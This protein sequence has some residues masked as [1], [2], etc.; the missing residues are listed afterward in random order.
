L[1][2]TYEATLSGL[3][4]RAGRQFNVRVETTAS[5]FGKASAACFA[6][7]PPDDVRLVY[8][9]RGGAS[10]YRKF[11]EAAGRAQ[12]F[13]WV[14]RDLAAR[15]PELVHAPDCSTR[16]GFAFLLGDLLMDAAWLASHRNVR[17]SEANEIARSCAL[18]ELHQTRRAC[19][20]LRQQRVAEG[21]PDVRSEHLAETYATA[22][23]EAT[24]FRAHPS[25]FLP[26]LVPD[27]PHDRRAGSADLPP[28][29]YLRARLFAAVLGEYF[30]TRH[31][32]RWWA[33]SKAADE[34]ID[35]WNTGS[36]YTVE[37]LASLGGLGA[38]SFDLLADR[39]NSALTR[40]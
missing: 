15:Y 14:S 31:G 22:L 3:G 32:H 18:V 40:E 13:A 12:H 38:L 9:S 5:E 36:R 39:F 21:A 8:H 23:E 16:A 11:F 27:D 37:E 1:R 20:R 25:L 6:L 24:H 10:Y 2:A 34:L 33:S 19:A 29:V 4:I 35:M 26:D 28:A 7:N 17:P 30:R